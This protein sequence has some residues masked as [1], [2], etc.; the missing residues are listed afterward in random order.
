MAHATA[1]SGCSKASQIIGIPD[2]VIR[3]NFETTED[4][5][6]AQLSGHSTTNEE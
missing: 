2:V 3:V 1:C 6:T 5:I 4:E